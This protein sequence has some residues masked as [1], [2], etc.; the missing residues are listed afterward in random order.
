MKL[1]SLFIPASLLLLSAMAITAATDN[2]AE[3]V[4]W[5]VGDQPI[6]KS[7]IEEMYQQLLY[8]KIPMQ[9]DPYCYIPEQL[10]LEKLYLHQA[11]LD[12]VEVQE[13]MVAQNV[14]AMIEYYINNLGSREKVEQV[15]H[16]TIPQLRE[17]QLENMRNRS[18][19]QEV[20]RNLTKNIKVTPGQVRKYFDALPKDSV[21][22]IPTQVEV[23]ILTVN[24]IIPREEIEDVKNR[25]RDFSERVNSGES[26]FSTL[27]ILY[28]EDP[29]SAKRGGE[30][31]FAGRSAYVPE[32]AAAAFNLNDPNKVSRIV[33]TEYGYHII[34]LIEK[35]GERVNV[36]HILLRPK[37]SDKDLMQAVNRLDSLKMDMD[38]AK[39]TFEE[40]VTAISQD[41][42]TRA[43]RGVMVNQQSGTTKFDMA[44]LPQEISRVVSTMQPGDV[45]Q[46]FIMKDPKSMRD[47]VAIVKL[48]N[49]IEAH[50]ANLGDDYQTIKDMYENAEQARILTSWI[51]KK[52]KETYVRI[53]PGWR[54]CDFMH[55]GWI[56]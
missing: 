33:Q 46:A 28:S 2:V 30:L 26:D 23:Q 43:N 37:V 34:Q 56:K 24:P 5:V 45:S 11:D 52:I 21:P 51:D 55:K 17:R 1:R 31:G 18:R 42:D 40:A 39:F 50:R 22:Y 13:N 25:L 49:R 47:I 29:E 53:E 16:M 7:D 12:T 9:G 32:F 4:A 14:D 20:Q 6:W 10:A 15:F 8:E 27:A 3:E 44:D 19:V 41:K 54:N 38:S 36:R 35:R 48:T